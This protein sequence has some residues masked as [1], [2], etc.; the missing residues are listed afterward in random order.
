MSEVT[1]GLRSIFSLA[2]VYSMAQRGIGAERFRRVVCSDYIRATAGM[3][4]VDIGSGTSDIVEHL[5]GVD[6]VGLEPSEQ[7][8]TAARERFGDKV[9]IVNEGIDTFDTEPWNETCDRVIAI[10]VL[11]HLSD[12][13]V[14]A[15][16][17]AASRLLKPDGVFV[18]VD[19]CLHDG[20]SRIAHALIVRDRGQNVRTV[21]ATMAL[22]TAAFDTPK[23]ELR[24]DLLRLPYSHAILTA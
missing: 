8:A 14:A 15:L 11:H 12:E 4:V 17:T 9:T 20:Q 13:Q 1:S 7:Y 5:A 19:P 6:Y 23:I 16:F 10:G 22:A 18:A 3:R 2:P 21:P 24:T